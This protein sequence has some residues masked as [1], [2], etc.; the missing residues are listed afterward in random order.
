LLS[1]HRWGKSPNAGDQTKTQSG[2]IPPSK[3][4]IGGRFR[5]TRRQDAVQITLPEVNLFCHFDEQNC[6]FAFFC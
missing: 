3:A 6:H 4:G 2:L 5:Q 1:F